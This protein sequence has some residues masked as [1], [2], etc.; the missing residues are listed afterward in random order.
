MHPISVHWTTHEYRGRHRRKRRAKPTRADRRTTFLPEQ[1]AR[2]EALG[3]AR[4]AEVPGADDRTAGVGLRRV[5]LLP[6]G[7]AGSTATRPDAPAGGIGYA[8]FLAWPGDASRTGRRAHGCPAPAQAAGRRRAAWLGHGM[9]VL[10]RH[11]V[12]AR[13]PALCLPCRGVRRQRTHQAH[14]DA[15]GAHRPAD[16]PALQQPEPDRRRA[17]AERRQR[18]RLS[19]GRLAGVGRGRV[20]RVEGRIRRR[21]LLD[22]P[23]GRADPGGASRTWLADARTAGLRHQRHQLLLLA[24]ADVGY[25]PGRDRRQDAA[26]ER[27]G[28]VRSSVGRLRRAEPRLELVRPAPRRRQRPDAL[29]ALRHAGPERAHRRHPVG[30]E[31]IDAAQAGGH[32]LHAGEALG[33]PGDPGQLH[34]RMGHSPAFRRASREAVDRQRRIQCRD[35]DRQHLLG[36]SGQGERQRDRRRLHGAE[37]LRA[38]QGAAAG[39]CTGALRRR[40]AAE[41][42]LSLRGGSRPTGIKPNRGGRRR[43]MPPARAAQR[44]SSG[45]ARARLGGGAA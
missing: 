32:R 45:P 2:L 19:P 15:H 43:A 16:R 38:A 10:Q 23:E 25:R 8:G 13:R 6:G 39:A 28:L 29:P 1:L 17:G 33:Q 14:R 9:V 3:L 35:H 5:R 34:R 24:A 31:R 22:G 21:V 41:A 36:G 27:R 26:G 44:R 42:P 30:P 20:A 7:A 40:G 18:L 11:P 37:R 12:G 4:P